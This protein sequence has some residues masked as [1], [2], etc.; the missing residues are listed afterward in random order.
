MAFGDVVQ[1]NTGTSTTATTAPT[2]PGAVTSGNIVVLTFAAD[3]YNGSPNS[4]WTQSPEMEQQTFHGG[5]LWWFKASS[6]GQAIPSYLIDSAVRSTWTLAEYEGPFDASP[7]DVSEGQFEQTSGNSYAT[8]DMT[9]TAGS[10]LLVAALVAQVASADLEAW[11]SFTGGFTQVASSLFNG[12]NPRLSIVQLRQVVTAN[13]STAYATS[14]SHGAQVSQS[15]SGFALALKASTGG[16]T[17]LTP[18]VGTTPVTGRALTLGL[19]IGMPA[20]P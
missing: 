1:S 19:T 5:Y 16:A 11:G 12:G 17:T 4:G 7:Y 6:G 10:R 8:A 3:D 15:R 14:G 18:G 20:V 13:G 9:P 2:L